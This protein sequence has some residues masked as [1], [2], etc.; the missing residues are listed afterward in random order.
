[1]R[2]DYSEQDDTTSRKTVMVIEL[3]GGPFD[4]VI[5]E[6]QGGWPVPDQFWL[7]S[8]DQKELHRYKTN[9]DRCTA[10]YVRTELIGNNSTKP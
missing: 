7:H 5:D 3:F 2:E 1:M 8:E 4:G 9:Q 6:V 10:T